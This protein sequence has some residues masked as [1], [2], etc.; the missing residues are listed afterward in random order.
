MTS[1]AETL[2]TTVKE[3]ASAPVSSLPD[4]KPIESSAP[5]SPKNNANISALLKATPSTIDALL[6]R[7]HRCLQTRAGADVVLLFLTYFTRLTGAVLEDLARGALRHNARKLISL[8]LTLPP[9]TTVTFS[10]KVVASPFAALGL[11]LSARLKAMS[12]VLTEVR[13]FGRLFGLLGLYFAAKKFIM[14]RLAPAD[15]EKNQDA[16]A[17]RTFDTLVSAAQIISLISFQA[18]E[19]VAYLA[20]KKVLPFTPATQGKLAQW[21]VRSWAMYIGMELGRLLVD[22]QRR[23]SAAGGKLTTKDAEWSANWK[24][25]FTGNLAWAPLTIHWSTLPKGLGL[26]E[27]AVSLLAFYPAC[28][29]MKDLWKA[30]A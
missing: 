26:N 10:N 16:K 21:S 6:A 30:N 15:P 9:S 13:T 22:R 14:S 7:L 12:G 18:T 8:A 2:T 5:S 27:L 1:T 29:A 19:N 24:K 20:S 4:G 17:E 23:V 25:E 28:G 11:A 3:P